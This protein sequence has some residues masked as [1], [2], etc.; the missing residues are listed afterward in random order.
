MIYFLFSA[1]GAVLGMLSTRFVPPDDALPPDV[2][3]T[4]RLAAIVG[5]VFGA[6]LLEWPA[7]VF[8]WAPPDVPRGGFGA[9]TVLGGILGGWLAVE[10][11]K[12]RL[13]F[14][15]ATGDRFALPLALALGVGR[16]GCV[17]AGCCPGVLIA[18]DSPWARV[19]LLFGH[20]ARFPAALLEA[21]FHAACAGLVLM[22]ASGNRLRGA[23]LATTLTLYAVA[24]FAL[25]FAREVPRPFIGLSYYQVLCLV[26][27]VVAGVTL[28]RRTYWKTPAAEVLRRA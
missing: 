19:S 20:G 1:S 8:H 22:L 28:L 26:L 17:V 11:A 3:R 16:L 25:E 23:R 18:A 15:G 21:Y 12:W 4:V 2:A 13:G 5:A 7:E 6:H 14:H 24:R 27:L 10:L 9:R